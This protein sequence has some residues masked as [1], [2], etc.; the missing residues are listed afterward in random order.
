MIDLTCPFPPVFSLSLSLPLPFGAGMGSGAA[1][2]RHAGCGDPAG[3]PVVG[4]ELEVSCW[5][6]ATKSRGTRGGFR[7]EMGSEEPKTS[8]AAVQH[9]LS[10]L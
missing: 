9:C 4:A 3:L 2:P 7:A 10:E 5:S 1:R 6:G 8:L